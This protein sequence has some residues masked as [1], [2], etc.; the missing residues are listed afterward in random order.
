LHCNIFAVYAKRL[1]T[2]TKTAAGDRTAT[3]DTHG[4]PERGFAFRPRSGSGL[5]EELRARI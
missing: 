2:G 5:V 3:R 4:G 1:A